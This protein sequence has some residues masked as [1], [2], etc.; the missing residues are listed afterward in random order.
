MADKCPY[1]DDYMRHLDTQ[2]KAIERADG[3]AQKALDKIDSLESA[4]KETEI[5][6][7][8]LY[9]TVEKVI[10]KV[11]NLSDQV[12]GLVT[13][14]TVNQSQTDNNANFNKKGKD[15]VYE[16]VKWLVF[17]VLGAALYRAGAT[18]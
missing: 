6:T 5:Y 4:H 7:K 11:D 12:A 16:I 17:L 14:L 15:L 2:D 10:D 18:P 3:K 13:A 1:H 8:E 9:K